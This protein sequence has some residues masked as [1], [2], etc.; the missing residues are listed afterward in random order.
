MTSTSAKATDPAEEDRVLDFLSAHPDVAGKWLLNRAGKEFVDDILRKKEKRSEG[1]SG[2]AEKED[3]EKENGN[4][5]GG[6]ARRVTD[7]RRF[8]WGPQ[9]SQA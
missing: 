9:G 5:V 7:S 1:R 3:A 4:K 8:G 6:D 2:K